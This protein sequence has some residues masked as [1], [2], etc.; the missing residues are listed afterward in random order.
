MIDNEALEE[1]NE[2]EGEDEEESDSEF[3]NQI[4]AIIKYTFKDI[5]KVDSDEQMD[6]EEE[7]AEALFS[8]ED[9]LELKYFRLENLIQRRPFLLSNTLLR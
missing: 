9:N 6:N 5:E 4:E 3:E 2:D 1:D 7:G 8:K